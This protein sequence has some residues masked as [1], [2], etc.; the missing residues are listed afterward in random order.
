MDSYT[1]FDG[2]PVNGDSVTID[3]G[4]YRGFVDE[5]E[6][7]RDWE[8]EVTAYYRAVKKIPHVELGATP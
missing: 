6:G 4:E 8:A 5:A 3:I 2:K 7:L 1:V